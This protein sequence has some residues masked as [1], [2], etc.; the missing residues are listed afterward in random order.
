MTASGWIQL[1]LFVGILLAITK[2]LG[3]FLYH[4]LDVNG[5]TFLDPLLRPI[6]RLLYKIFGVDPHQEQDWKHYGAAMLMFSMVTMLFTYGV[7]RLQAHLP[8]HQYVDALSDKTDLNPALVFNTSASFTTNT[9]WQNYSGENTMSYFSQM[10]ALASHNFWSAAV[11]IA[12]AAALVRGIAR[13][14]AKTIGNFWVDLVRIH[15][16]VLIP[17]CIVYALFLVS[18]GIIRTSSRRR[19]SP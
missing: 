3:I 14:K 13:D 6:E 16:Y 8:W 19:R 1:L 4:V 2:P 5:K 15:L 7:L 17:L 12:I 18:Q 9:N 10:V 11:G